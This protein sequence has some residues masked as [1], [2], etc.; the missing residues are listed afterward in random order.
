L[1]TFYDYRDGPAVSAGCD[2]VESARFPPEDSFLI[3]CERGAIEF[4]SRRERALVAWPRSDAP[5][6]PRLRSRG[7]LAEELEHFAACA[8]GGRRPSR[9]PAEE[10]REAVRLAWAEVKSAQTGKEV[11]L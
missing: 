1:R 6:H 7:G 2:W 8:C 4:A 3:A 10:A 11:A 5:M 9:F